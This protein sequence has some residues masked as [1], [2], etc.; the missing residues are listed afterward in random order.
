M[1]GI[2]IKKKEKKRERERRKWYYGTQK[3]APRRSELQLTVDFNDP[4]K[5]LRQ[6]ELPRATD[7]PLAAYV[8]GGWLFENCKGWGRNGR[9]AGG[10]LSSLLPLEDWRTSRREFNCEMYFAWLF[11]NRNLRDSSGNLNKF[12]LSNKL[13]LIY[14]WTFA[15]AKQTT[16][17]LEKRR[18]IK[19]NI[20][21]C[22]QKFVKITNWNSRFPNMAS[23]FWQS[24]LNI[25]ENSAIHA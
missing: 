16:I 21:Y 24:V 7:S 1:E 12:D 4:S 8:R 13:S 9:V 20:Y 11:F 25:D 17:T 23:F 5:Q 3:F 15:I 2:K 19:I 14:S 22:N 6:I 18:K 10:G